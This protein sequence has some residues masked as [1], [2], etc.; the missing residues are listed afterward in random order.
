MSRGGEPAAGVAYLREGLEALR[1]SGLVMSAVMFLGGF[2]TVLVQNGQIAEA[3]SIIDEALT[4]SEQDE[5]R[6]FLAELLR[7]KGELLSG[8]G[9][10][11]EAEAHFVQA[12]DWARRQ[13][14]LPWELRVATSRVRLI[15]PA[16]RPSAARTLL[17]P[18]VS[19]FN[20][21]FGRADLLAA[22]DILAQAA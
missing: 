1:E 20:E 9:A 8:R 14:A 12:D 18:V 3:Q 15:P 10:R 22:A 13:G 4:R 16:D 2:A 7:V 11:A 21:G 19:R 6:W 5:E 17:A